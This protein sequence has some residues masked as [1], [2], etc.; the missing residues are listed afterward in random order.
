MTDILKKNNLD[1]TS[2]ACPFC[3]ESAASLEQLVAHLALRHDQLKGL[4][5]E[6]DAGM[7]T[8]KPHEVTP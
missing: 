4:S 1:E 5:D 3:D 2:R 7:S 6:L 8:K